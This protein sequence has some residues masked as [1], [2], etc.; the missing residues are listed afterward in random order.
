VR[1]IGAILGILVLLAAVAAVGFW[2][3][4]VALAPPDDPLAEGSSPVTYQVVE[5]T[6][7]QSL[8]FAAVAEWKASPLG[9]AWTPGVVTSVAFKPGARVSAG[10]VLFTVDLRP[11]VMAQGKTPAFRD[12]Q[13]GDRGADVTQLQA[14]LSHL[15]FLD[16]EPDGVFGDATWVATRAW[17]QSVG[18]TDDAV[19]RQG[20][21][22]F[23]AELPVRVVAT[24]AL[25]VGALLSGGEVVISGL[26]SAPTVVV[27]LTPD[28]RNLVPLSGQVRLSYPDGAWNAVIA[29]VGDSAEDNGERIDLILEAPGGGPVCRDACDEWIP[30]VGTTS[31][32]ADIVIIPETTGPVVP[33]A[34]IVTDPG[35]GQAVLTEDGTSV[36]IDV[37]ASTDALAVV[38]GIEPGE[39][40]I[41]PFAE[42]PAQ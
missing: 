22:L 35:G 14:F 24:E 34:A 19:V 16:Q 38:N 32:A 18:V 9:R 7:G 27:P 11:V 26:E 20:D 31:F 37:L 36:P 5:Q 4:R 10:D 17:Q 3:G 23:A 6:I 8:Q 15:G 40:V 29:R 13:F 12:L 1:R 21:L 28:Q 33:V 30:P 41:L 25:T 2:A 39:V 42:P